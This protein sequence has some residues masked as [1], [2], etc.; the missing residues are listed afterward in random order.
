MGLEDIPALAGIGIPC[1]HCGMAEI[2][3]FEV[4]SGFLQ[5]PGPGRL[6]EH[7]TDPALRR[8]SGSIGARQRG[9]PVPQAATAM[10]VLAGLGA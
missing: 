1:A 9:I 5:C 6:A 10:M 7:R 3:D 8:P 4:I 2:D